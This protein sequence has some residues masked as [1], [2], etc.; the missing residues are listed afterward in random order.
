MIGSYVRTDPSTGMT[1]A[2]FL[3]HNTVRINVEMD[4][5]E[6]GTGT[7]F[8]Y[9]FESTNGSIVGALVTNKH[10]LDNS[11]SATLV[12]NPTGKDDKIDFN[13]QKLVAN[14]PEFSS[15]W[16]KHPNPDIDIAF[17][18]LAPI[19]IKLAQEKSPFMTFFRRQNFPKQEEWDELTALEQIV[20]VGYPSGIWDPVNNLPVLRTGVTASHPKIDYRGRPEFLIDA[21]V[22]QGSSGSPV[23]L[24]E[25][26]DVFL[27]R[28]LNMGKDKPRLAGILSDVF[29]YEEHG[30]MKS[31]PIPT[32]EKKIPITRIPN[33][34]G[35]VIKSTQ[36]DG[37]IPLIDKK[38]EEQ[39]LKKHD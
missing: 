34:L 22:Y 19:I 31:M 21:A 7:G 18:N 38:L 5:G 36:L 33:N 4:N 26:K 25:S 15:Y 14:I 32:I 39:K 16:F 1:Y 37:F 28:E 29:A 9:Q 24:Y 12:F 35:I 2:E 11:Q 30:E 27:G 10:V 6:N 23:F 13:S 20:I 3:S 17:I 8:L